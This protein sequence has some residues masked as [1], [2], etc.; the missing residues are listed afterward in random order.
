MENPTGV[1]AACMEVE[2]IVS[3]AKFSMLSVALGIDAYLH[4]Q[5]EEMGR[6]AFFYLFLSLK[7]WEKVKKLN[8]YYIPEHPNNAYLVYV[9][10]PGKIWVM[11]MHEFVDKERKLYYEQLWEIYH[12]IADE[13]QPQRIALLYF[14]LELIANRKVFDG[15]SMP[16]LIAISDRTIY[17]EGNKIVIQ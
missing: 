10:G 3:R 15:L 12:L 5:T 6:K 17:A 11:E 8:K 1:A 13:S 7:I 9:R 16:A 14:A 2:K 4:T